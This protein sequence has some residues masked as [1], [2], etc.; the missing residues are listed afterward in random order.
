MKYSFINS[1]GF[2]ARLDIGNPLAL[3]ENLL[4][5]LGADFA[6][7]L[8]H[9]LDVFLLKRAHIH[10]LFAGPAR[11]VFIVFEELDSVGQLEA[12]IDDAHQPGLV[13]HAEVFGKVLLDQA[14]NRNLDVGDHADFGV[15]GHLRQYRP[16]GQRQLEKLGFVTGLEFDQKVVQVAPEFRVRVGRG[17][18]G[19]RDQHQRQALGG[20]T[21]QSFQTLQKDGAGR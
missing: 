9:H 10:G 3:D 1:S 8:K 19:E 18:G 7:D 16:V 20:F 11:L 2:L 12:E 15:F 14:Q 4:E 6:V 21:L 17:K 13:D 5:L